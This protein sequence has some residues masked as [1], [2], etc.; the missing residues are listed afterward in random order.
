MTFFEWLRARGRKMAWVSVIGTFVALLVGF[1]PHVETLRKSFPDWPKYLPFA[2]HAIQAV[3]ILFLF[4]FMGNPRTDFA[5]HKVASKAVLQF[6]AKWQ[7]I[8][9]SWLILYLLFCLEAF[10]DILGANEM[11]PVWSILK[12]FVNNWTSLFFLMAFL[13][14]WTKTITPDGNYMP[15]PWFPWAAL[16]I[17]MTVVQIGL[18]LPQTLSAGSTKVFEWLSGVAG[19]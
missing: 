10:L 8:W 12:N 1:A 19:G 14:L 6:H 2:L 7:K 15:L 18:S 13:V 11:R 16:I 3:A 4:F 17:V 5:E 9:I